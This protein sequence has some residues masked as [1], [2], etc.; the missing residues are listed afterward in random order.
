[1]N[2]MDAYDRGGLART[3]DPDPADPAYVDRLAETMRAEEIEALG[4]VATRGPAPSH[5]WV[6]D[7]YDPGYAFHVDPHGNPV[8]ASPKQVA[9]SVDISINYRRDD[10]D[11]AFRLAGPPPTLAPP[12]DVTVTFADGTTMSFQ[13]ATIT[14][15]H[16]S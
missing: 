7:A 5:V 15:E 2:W 12:H 8:G 14:L 16:R 4:P 10:P 3:G 1:M 13:T 9:E 11:D 6:D